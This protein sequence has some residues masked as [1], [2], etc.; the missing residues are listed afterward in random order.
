MST[1]ILAWRRVAILLV[2]ASSRRASS[3][4]N[5]L[6]RCSS[7][8]AVVTK[9]LQKKKPVRTT[10]NG[11]VLQGCCD[12]CEFCNSTANAADE[13]CSS[14]A[15][16]QLPKQPKLFYTSRRKFVGYA[17]AL[18]GMAGFPSSPAFA[19]VGSGA[20][21]DVDPIL[22]SDKKSII[23]VSAPLPPFSTTRTYRNIVLSN[24]LKVVLVK[25]SMA[26]RSSVALSIDGAGQFAE[27]EYIPG[28]AHLMEHIVLSSTRRLGGPKV[29]ERKA[30]RLWKNGDAVRQIANTVA[31]GSS[32]GEQDFEDWL[33]ENDG[34][35][36]AFTAPGFVC[37]HF[38]GPHEVRSSGAHLLR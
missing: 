21:R 14:Q 36:N 38:N 29:L 3:F 15:L 33:A 11:V 37:F 30:R 19:D 18:A 20:M 28:L 26:Q 25:D 17:A 7:S 35:S 10:R 16:V 27:P 8:N 12:C 2:I 31:D 13:H 5:P 23:A 24:G 32:S 1:A 4:C 34:D 6:P 9:T 22:A